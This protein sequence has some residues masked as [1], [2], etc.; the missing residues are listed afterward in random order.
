M[1]GFLQNPDVAGNEGVKDQK[2][3]WLVGN[4]TSSHRYCWSE[5]GRLKLKGPDGQSLEWTLVALWK[6]QDEVEL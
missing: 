5:C 2:R 1:F 4:T 3:I 6:T